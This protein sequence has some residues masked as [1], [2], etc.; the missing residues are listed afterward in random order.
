MTLA[1]TCLVG[2]LLGARHATEPDHLV[3]VAAITARTRGWAGAASTG[4]RWALGHS[5]PVVLVGLALV[6][7]GIA[8][9]EG[10]RAYAE[11][12]VALMLVLLGSRN[13][14][15]HRDPPIAAPP[16]LV[17]L[18][19]GLAGSASITLILV[20]TD[21]TTTAALVRLATFTIGTVVGMMACSVIAS[22]SFERLA[23]P[24]VVRST[25]AL[26]MLMGLLLFGR[27]AA[28]HWS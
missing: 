22:V 8:V 20:A 11:L 27:V 26:S 24:W 21:P 25:G 4:A 28:E 3:A 14:S 5:L 7:G 2:I 9:P 19:H 16:M 10:W 6:L 1:L 23:R 12:P 17:G 15:A 18:V 13:V